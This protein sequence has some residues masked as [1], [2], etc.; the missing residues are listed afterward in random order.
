MKK[1]K[2]KY[3]HLT[4]GKRDR[5]EALL[6]SGHGQ[7]E[8]SRVLKVDKST[9]SGEV[10]R[11]RRKK[12]L[13]GGT[14]D[15]P[16]ESTVAH[17]KAYV[18]RKYAK[19]QGQKIN[20]N[21]VLKTYVTAG[22]KQ[23]QSPDEIS[24]RM[25]LEKQP[26]Y[27]SKSAIYEW[28]Y[29][30]RGSYWCQYL[31]AQRY[32]PKR[33]QGVKARKVLIPNRISILERPLG[34]TNRTRY[35]HY[36]GDTMVSGRKTGSKAALSVLYERKTKFIEANK[37]PNLKPSS[38]IHALKN[39]LDNKKVLSVTQDN[40]IENMKH[41]ELEVAT[42]FCDAYSSWQKGGVENAVKMIRRF[43]PK[44][45]DLAQYSENYVKLVVKILNNKPRKSL[46]YKTPYEV[47]V[48]HNLFVE[49]KNPEVA[50]RG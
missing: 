27:V 41:E 24:G 36:E 50:L 37:I 13:K 9:I 31:Y 22:L 44:R 32:R 19:Y 3:G 11:N 18:R 40:G 14:R 29:T 42:Y 46:G 21:E 6:K 38:H 10:C 2:Q 25:R 49:N 48:E 47:M 4:Q 43:I 15:G 28:L 30:A 16:Y 26:F 17:H 12:R 20:E 7:N 39:M 8:I 5:I 45:S 33:R 34:A 1:R 35:G 23:F